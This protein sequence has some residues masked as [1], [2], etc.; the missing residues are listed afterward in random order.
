MTENKR[1]VKGK[2]EYEEQ[3]EKERWVVDD[4]GTL[5]DM[6]TRETY[7]IVEEVVDVLNYYENTCVK[8]EK[9]I[10]ELKNGT[11]KEPLPITQRK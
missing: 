3:T 6:V 11:Y 4:A 9:T 10:S 2:I 7:D 8:Y 5:I 1:L